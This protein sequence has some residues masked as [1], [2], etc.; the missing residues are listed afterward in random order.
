MKIEMETGMETEGYAV[1]F[2][3]YTFILCNMKRSVFEQG[4]KSTNELNNQS[5]NALLF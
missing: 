2:L 5:I 3:S 1:F 4:A